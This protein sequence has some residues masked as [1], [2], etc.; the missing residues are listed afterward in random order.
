MAHAPPKYEQETVR[1]VLVDG[2]SVDAIIYLW[3]DSLQPALYQ[4]DWSPQEFEDK[5]LASCEFGA[6]LLGHII[7]LLL[8][9]MPPVKPLHCWPV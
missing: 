2:S 8:L 7:L 5:H 6:A 3:Q 4:P 9:L 1:P